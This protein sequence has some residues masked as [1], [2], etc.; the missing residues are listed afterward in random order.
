M[1]ESDLEND[2]RFIEDIYY[3]LNPTEALLL[4]SENPNIK[5]TFDED[6]SI[7]D[8][9]VLVGKKITEKLKLP[10]KPD[11]E[12]ILSYDFI[13]ISIEELKEKV[14]QL[15]EKIARVS[16]IHLNKDNSFREKEQEAN[17]LF[18]SPN[19]EVLD[20]PLKEETSYDNQKEN[21]VNHCSNDFDDFSRDDSN[22][23]FDDQGFIIAELSRSELDQPESELIVVQKDIEEAEALIKFLEELGSPELLEGVELLEYI[24]ANSKLMKLLSKPFK[25]NL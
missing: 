15:K 17:D 10:E 5:V 25:A 14:K 20:I 21:E 11:I 7:A 2:T 4:S 6:G 9:P 1:Q 3:R 8:I 22:L 23:P 18:Q 19:G 12:I 24:R 13:G 16:S